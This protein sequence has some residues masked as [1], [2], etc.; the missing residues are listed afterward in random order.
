MSGWQ[1]GRRQNIKAFRHTSAASIPVTLDNLL[2]FT[3]ETQYSC[4][5]KLLCV[6]L[7]VNATAYEVTTSGYQAQATEGP[8]Q[9]T[10]DT[11]YS[12]LTATEVGNDTSSGVLP[13]SLRCVS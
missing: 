4:L 9:A 2:A 7:T 8:V 10:T 11:W 1:K 12:N 6:R 5:Y 3:A 13:L